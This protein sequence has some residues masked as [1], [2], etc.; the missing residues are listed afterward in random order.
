MFWYPHKHKCWVPYFWLKNQ[1]GRAY[2]A[3]YLSTLAGATASWPRRLAAPRTPLAQAGHPQSY[4]RCCPPS[5]KNKHYTLTLLRGFFEQYSDVGLK[6]LF[7][8]I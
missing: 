5:S 3:R 1:N 4:R 6:V 2:C 8:T 7:I